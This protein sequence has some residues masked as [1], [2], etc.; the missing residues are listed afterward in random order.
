MNN[1]IYWAWAIKN[2]VCTVSWVILAIVFGKWWIAL[3]GALFLSSIERTS[4]NSNDK[5]D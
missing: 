5:E 2:I 3:F 1:H 4:E